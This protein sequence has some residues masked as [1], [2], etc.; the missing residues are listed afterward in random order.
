MSQKERI[1]LEDDYDRWQW[2]CPNGH[3]DW[4]P[5]NHHFW[6]AAC[7]R[8]PEVDASFDELRD[9]KTGR[10]YERDDVELHTPAGP[11]DSDLDGRGS[12]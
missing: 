4:E 2:T 12:A 5:T 1:N 11:Y 10:L 9:Q 6:C 7:A 3:H 8:I